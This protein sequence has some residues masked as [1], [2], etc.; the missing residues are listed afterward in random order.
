MKR[1]CRRGICFILTL[2]LFAGLLPALT[3]SA[4]TLEEKQRAVVLTAWAYYDKGRP[5]QYDSIELSVVTK[6]KGGARRITMETAP[7][8]AVS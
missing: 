2:V 6:G 4:L 7:E 8:S 5:V 1:L 3:A